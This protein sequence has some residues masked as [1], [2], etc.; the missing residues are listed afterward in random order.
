MELLPRK[1]AR[2]RAS[3]LRRFG[4]TRHVPVHFSVH[5]V[6]TD[7]GETACGLRNLAHLVR[8][9]QSWEAWLGIYRCRG[10]HEAHPMP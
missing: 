4:E 7:L 6:D 5:R 9:D 10:C 1:P 3:L 2:G 8:L